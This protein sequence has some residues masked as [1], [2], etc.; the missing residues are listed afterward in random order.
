MAGAKI[1][2]INPITKYDPKEGLSARCNF[3]SLLRDRFVFSFSRKSKLPSLRRNE[4]E[5]LGRESSSEIK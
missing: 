5:A 1:T 4:L 3:V 2:K